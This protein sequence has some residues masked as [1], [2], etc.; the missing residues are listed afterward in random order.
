MRVMEVLSNIRQLNAEH[1]LFPPGATVVVGVSGGADSL[2][3]LHALCGLREDFEIVLHVATLDHGLR[4]EASAADAAFVVETARAWEVPVT[5]GRVDVGA[6]AERYK[7]G[8]E[9]AARQSRYRFLARV[10]ADQSA[11]HI[12]VAHN[13][14]DQSETVLMH[15]LRGTGLAGLRGMLP[16]SPLSEDHLLSGGAVLVR[17]LLT[18][19]RAAIEA[20]CSVHGL[21]PRFDRSN[22]DTAY[23]RNRLRHQV[24]PFLEKLNPNLRAVLRQTAEIVAADYGLLRA[25]HKATWPAVCREKTAT[26]VTF[27]LAAWRALPLSS[28]RAMLRCAISE[29]QAGLHDVSFVHVADAVRV[30]LSGT[31][32]AQATLPGGLS[33]RVGYETLVIAADEHTPDPPPWPL[34]WSAETLPVDL[35]AETALPDSAWRLSFQMVRGPL[36]P[37]VLKDPWRAA[38]SARVVVPDAEIVLRT[39]RP[40]DRFAPQGLGGHT[41]KLSKFMI[42]LKIPKLWRDKIPLLVVNGEIMWVVGWRVSQLAVVSDDIDTYFVAAFT[43]EV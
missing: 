37:L 4:G 17:P 26:A 32:G 2:C 41:K 1:G 30:A 38:L 10:A 7:L 24:I 19:P 33:L 9:E 29:L 14:D 39:R 40:G 22:R 42:D 31:T 23:L 16:V 18:T 36:D 27:D 13:A 43:S 12:A 35:E 11:R 15:F 25:V 28:Q 21:Q 8:I 6:L 5:M 34:L 20:Y 3:L